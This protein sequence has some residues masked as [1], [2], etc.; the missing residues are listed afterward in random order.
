MTSWSHVQVLT[1]KAH[2]CDFIC[3]YNPVKTPKERLSWIRVGP[4]SSLEMKGLN[5]GICWGSGAQNCDR[6]YL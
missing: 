4:K 3:R 1:A 2:N 6:I 5:R